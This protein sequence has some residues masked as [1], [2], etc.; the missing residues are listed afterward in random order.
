MS[1]RAVTTS[2][3]AYIM[4]NTALLVMQ[5]SQQMIEAA[6]ITSNVTFINSI[7]VFIMSNDS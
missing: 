6:F 4:G 1:S 7:R 3:D 2:T 5:H